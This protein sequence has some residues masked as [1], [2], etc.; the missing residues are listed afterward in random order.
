VPTTITA[1]GGNSTIDRQTP[2]G[3]SVQG[4]LEWTC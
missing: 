3:I 1:I 4:T 2:G